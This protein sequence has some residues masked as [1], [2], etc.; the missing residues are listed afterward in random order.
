MNR[1]V[2]KVFAA[3]VLTI[4]GKWDNS[5]P[6]SSLMILRKRMI[7]ALK[8]LWKPIRKEE[9]GGKNSSRDK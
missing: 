9:S 1:A 4:I 5:L 2:R 8:N 7:E 6:V 3:N